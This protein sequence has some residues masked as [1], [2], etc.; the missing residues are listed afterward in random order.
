[1]N[2]KELKQWKEELKNGFAQVAYA[3]DDILKTTIALVHNA[4][5][6]N[7]G[8]NWIFSQFDQ[9]IDTLIKEAIVRDREKLVKE[10][11]KKVEKDSLTF[12]QEDI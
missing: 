12:D 5:W 7:K 11:E 10:I 9:K 6:I 2:P 3:E 1:M 8:L 4:N